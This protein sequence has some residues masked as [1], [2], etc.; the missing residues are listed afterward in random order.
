M[1]YATTIGIGLLLLA[2]CQAP[3]DERTTEPDLQVPEAWA[4][5]GPSETVSTDAWWHA[6]ADD[7]L[8]ARIEE[9]LAHNRDLAASAAR[10]SRAAAQARIAGADLVPA[11]SL[12]G[13]AARSQ[14][15]FVGLPIPGADVLTS[16][17]TSYGVS[18]DVSWELD[19]WGRLLAGREAAAEELVASAEDHRAARLSI[20]A[21]TAKAWLAWQQAL[22][23]EALAERTVTS[24]ERTVELA[25]RRFDSGRGSSLDVHRAQGD[26]AS[27]RAAREARR[28]LTERTGR[29]LEL[30]L[31][32]HPAG[33]LTRDPRLPAVP[34]VPA[35]GVPS[36]LLRSRPDLVAA[37]ARL[38]AADQ[39]VWEA[40]ALLYPQINLS[41]SGGRT[42]NDLGDLVDSDFDV[43]SLLAGISRPLFQGGRLEAGVDLADAQAREAA[44]TYA[45][46]VLR[47]FAEV[48][49]A[50]AVEDALERRSSELALANHEADRA[51]ELA[52]DRYAA[53]RENLTTLLDSQRRAL[54]SESELLTARFVRLESR[55]DLYL[56]LGGGMPVEEE[57]PEGIE[58]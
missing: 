57:T 19:L 18:I 43:W 27:A 21:Q 14:Q 15:V 56:A 39:R 29:Q 16:R 35:V 6:F 2:A 22:Q 9:A 12:S 48:E 28:E 49:T 8:S 24:F 13:S 41:A 54:A 38:R 51:L 3:G 25:R 37:D 30:L 47:A 32:R 7:E 44:A 17:S 34:A 5:G 52:E 11:V 36:D 26:L 20:A 23:Q 31:G 42:S 46:S 4:A 10:V 1:R 50:L 33:A 55:V 53:G 40:R 58:P 45:S